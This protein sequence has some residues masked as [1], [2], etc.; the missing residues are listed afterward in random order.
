MG[1]IHKVVHLQL[2]VM[3]VLTAPQH[4]HPPQPL[5]ATS[6]MQ[7]HGSMFMANRHP[8]LIRPSCC[9]LLLLPDH[10]L[11]PEIAKLYDTDRAAFDKAAR[12]HTKQHAM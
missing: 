10:S 8:I 2:W 9:L 7:C 5:V 12:E 4:H 6:V 3:P 11:Q 1:V